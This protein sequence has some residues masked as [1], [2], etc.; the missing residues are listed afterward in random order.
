MRIV[1]AG[2]FQFRKYGKA[3]VSTELKLF[4]GF[5]RLNHNVQIFSERDTAAFEALFGWRDLGKKKANRR[6]VETC[7]NFQPDL[8]VLGHCD[9]IKN[10]T[11]SEIRGLVPALRIAYRNVDA[12]YQGVTTSHIEARAPFV[13]HLF[14]TTAGEQGKSL[15]DDPAK[16]S[17]IPNPVDA[18]IEIYDNSQRPSE[19]F[20]RDLFFAGRGDSSLPRFELVR[21]LKSQLAGDLRFETF[22]FDGAS[23]VWGIDYDRVLGGSKMGLSLNRQ[24]GSVLSSSA[25]VA[26]LMGNGV[27]TFIHQST[28]LEYFFKDMAV[29]FDSRDDL[30]EKARHFHTRDDERCKLASAGHDYLHA[31]MSS[32]RVAQF[33]IDRTFGNPEADKYPWSDC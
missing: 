5:V 21:E 9:I 11:L 23:A 10:E 30:L 13:D 17:Y 27:L 4:N 15:A 8:L 14:L 25:R 3:Q 26:Q 2:H 19:A 31:E 16:V 18:A 22:G 24:E 6:L 29:F 12:L 32:A 20:D 28:G 7:D 33:I 1:Q